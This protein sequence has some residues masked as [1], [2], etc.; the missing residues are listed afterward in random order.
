MTIPSFDTTHLEEICNVLA[1]TDTGLTG[2]EI[3]KLLRRI[4]ATDVQPSITKR[5]RLFEA[6]LAKQQCD[7]CGNNVAA[8][9]QQAMNPVRYAGSSEYFERKRAELNTVLAFAGY[10]LGEDGKL[11]QKTPAKTLTEAEQRAHRLRSELSRRGVHADVL[12]FCQAELLQDNFFHA[13]FEATKSVADKLRQKSGLT[14]DGSELVDQSLGLG[15]TGHPLLALNTLQ[16][17]TER[18]EHK[19]FTNLLKGIFGAFRNVTAHAPKIT[20]PIK[21]QDAMDLM[22]LA[23]LLHRRLDAAVRTTHPPATTLA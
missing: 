1:D 8:F 22:S 13:V 11:S 10:V 18:S 14:A 17:E 16:T 2:S 19:G 21:E 4:S 6:L 9:I 23:S 5:V 15:K 12:R 7:G 20:W 3:G